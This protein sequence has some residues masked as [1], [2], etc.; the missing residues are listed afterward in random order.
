MASSWLISANGKMYDH[1]ASFTRNGFI[2]WRQGSISYGIGDTV[3]IYCTRP[4]SR[5]MYRCVIERV[6]M[7]F[8][9]IC[10]DRQFWAVQEEY[11]KAKSGDYARLRLV[12]QTDNPALVLARLKENGLK[13]APQGPMHVSRELEAYILKHF[14]DFYVKGFF[15]EPDGDE[16]LREGHVIQISVNRY[17]RSSIARRKCIEYNGENCSICGINFG[18]RYGEFAKGFIHVHHLKPL[19]SIGEDYTVDYRR[20]LIP[21][22]PN[23]HAMIHRL[24]GGEEMSI[25]E[26]RTALNAPSVH[27]PGQKII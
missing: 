15:V 4:L 16:E 12:D 10:D 5:I 8:S 19:H 6:H 27:G 17:E 11:E 20:D 9:Q 13:A 3:Y 25:D 26:L 1:A 14:D 24:P 7:K 2:D 18:D 22:C 23:C 21:V